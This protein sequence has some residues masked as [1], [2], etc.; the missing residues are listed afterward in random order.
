LAG[1]VRS[2]SKHGADPRRIGRR[3]GDLL[4]ILAMTV[5]TALGVK[6]FIMDASHV[7]TRSMQDVL[8]PGD[9]VLVNKFLYGARTPLP[10][11]GDNGPLPALRLPALRDPRSGDI[12]LFW[13]P[14]RPGPQGARAAR[15]Y[16]K[17]CAAGPG[18]SL[19]IEAGTVRV[20]GRTFARL[21]GDTTARIRMVIPRPGET[22]RVDGGAPA[23]LWEMVARDLELSGGDDG[24]RGVGHGTQDSV[25]A[26]GSSPEGGERMA[27][28]HTVM[29]EFY[30]VLG[31]RSAISVDSRHWGLI[32]REWVIGTPIIV[33]WSVDPASQ[34]GGILGRLQGVR[35]SRIGRLVR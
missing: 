24:R 35:W 9:Y 2:S 16:V 27:V 19:A 29:N 18:D 21:E 23:L 14:T 12:L 10:L 7:P 31:D 5:L 3:L 15:Q 33:Y 13:L 32:P 11:S 26:S 6:T 4:A 17:R 30:F 8:E 25:R 22:V 20:N 28:S 1:S 34:E